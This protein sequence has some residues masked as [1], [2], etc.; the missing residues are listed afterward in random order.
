MQLP[1]GMA[2]ATC[3]RNVAAPACRSLTAPEGARPSRVVLLHPAGA[4]PTQAAAP[5]TTSRRSA[6]PAK[7]CVSAS[8]LI[9]K[10]GSSSHRDGTLIPRNDCQEDASC[11]SVEQPAREQNRRSSRIAASSRIWCDPVT[12]LSYVLCVPVVDATAAEQFAGA[13]VLDCER[14]RGCPSRSKRKPVHHELVDDGLSLRVRQRRG[15]VS[16]PVVA[17]VV[18]PDRRVGVCFRHE[19]G[20]VSRPRP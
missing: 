20:V 11:S 18:A 8:S 9:H 12:E 5:R 19:P 6:C 1:V 17:T 3:F 10:P 2:A 16:K 14:N 13:R 7:R 4:S 15:R